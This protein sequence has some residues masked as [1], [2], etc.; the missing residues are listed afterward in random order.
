MHTARELAVT[1]AKYLHHDAALQEVNSLVAM[2]GDG[3]R[4]QWKIDHLVR[5]TS[6]SWLFD[7]NHSC[8]R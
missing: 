6:M 4:I 7:A 1:V 2:D 3:K 8:R 5:C